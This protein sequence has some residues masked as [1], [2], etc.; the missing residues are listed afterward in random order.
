MNEC[1]PLMHGGPKTPSWTNHGTSG[2]G[3]GGGG[4]TSPVG[5]PRFPT[6]SPGGGTPRESAEGQSPV[7]VGDASE[8]RAYTLSQ[9]SLT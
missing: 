3:G 6:E 1:K 4:S 9:F 2:S 5:S 7:S 8:A